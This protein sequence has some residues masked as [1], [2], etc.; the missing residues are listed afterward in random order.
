MASTDPLAPVSRA[1]TLTRAGMVAERAAR[2]LWLPLSLA[3]LMVTAWAFDLQTRLPGDA[4]VWLAG[5]GLSA[6][7]ATLALGLWRFRWPTRAEAIARLD[8]TLP[9]RPL[10]AL[11]DS[12]A[13]N[14]E[15]PASAALWSAHR[16]RMAARAASA[17]PVAPA[18]GLA[19]HDPFGLRLVAMTALGVAILFAV[20]GQQG[21]LAGLSGSAGAAIGPS[22]EG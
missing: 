4:S 11:I 10:A 8:Q 16:A 22:W 14:A 18:P 2:A 19:R 5:A 21:P 6:I 13:I 12:Q 1:L 17:R 15:D 3:L 7:V 9:G 20:P